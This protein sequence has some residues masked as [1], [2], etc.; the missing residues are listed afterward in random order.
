LT[1]DVDTLVA[2]ANLD[3][4]RLEQALADRGWVV[5]RADPQGEL[6]RLRHA[7][8][9]IADIVVAGTDYQREAIARAR[10]EQFED[11]LRVPVLRIEDVIVHKLIAGRS[12]DIADIEAILATRAKFDRAYVERWA[13]FWDVTDRWRAVN[14]AG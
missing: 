14:A 13:E 9:G 1:Q 2:D 4:A 3:L 5:R 12:Q 7:T 6:L 10:V 11:G 8:L